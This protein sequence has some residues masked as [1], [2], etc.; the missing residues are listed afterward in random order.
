MKNTI[1]IVALFGFLCLCSACGSSSSG[2]GGGDGGVTDI[3]ETMPGDIVV[4]SPTASVGPSPSISGK[5]I[6]K[7][8]TSDY[9]TKKEALDALIAGTGTCSFTIESLGNLSFA[10]CYGPQVTVQNHPDDAAKTVFGGG[11]LGI[12]NSTNTNNAAEACAAA[13]MNKVV[14][15]AASRVDNFVNIL[16]AVACAGVK[17][18]K[19]PP[20]VL[21]TLDLSSVISS[22][23]TI[24]GLAISTATIERLADDSTNPVYKFTVAG[25]M[26]TGGKSYDT[27]I[28]LKHIPTATD[29]STYKGKISFSFSSTDPADTKPGNCD[30]FSAV[31]SDGSVQAGM[32]LYEKASASSVTYEMNMAEFCGADTDPFD[33]NNNIAG[34]D[35]VSATNPTG[36]ANNYNYGLFNVNPSN[37]TGTVVFGWSAGFGGEMV[38]ALNVTTTAAADGSA[39]G[40][41]YFGFGPSIQTSTSTDRGSIT[42]MYC[43]WGGTY[44]PKMAQ[45][46]ELAR[47]VGGTVFG[48]TFDNITFAPTNDCDYNGLLTFK[49]SSDPTLLTNPMIPNDN[50]NGIGVLNDLIDTETNMDFTRPAAPADVGG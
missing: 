33:S 47:A 8:A 23:V 20:A 2:G 24:S 25:A 7:D 19:T 30:D 9:E 4:S 3:S 27:S 29:N 6:F 38:R 21:S 11:D 1:L 45:H 10:N 36:W 34:T 48:T 40:E 35:S 31:V 32:I 44:Q 46:Q 43:N 49:Y 22:F 26:T 42:G 14:E 28:I 13:Q 18:G 17:G 16:G 15:F 37:G 41:S 39:T 5:S 50:F 12:W